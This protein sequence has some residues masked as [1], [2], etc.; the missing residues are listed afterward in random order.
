MGMQD[1]LKNIS[2]MDFKGGK[3]FGMM[4]YSQQKTIDSKE[5]HQ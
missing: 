5:A 4:F 1:Y 2:Q 3:S